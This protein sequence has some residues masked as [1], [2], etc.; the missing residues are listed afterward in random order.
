VAPP[1][2]PHFRLS[3]LG[4][5]C[6]LSAS[7]GACGGDG[8]TGP[9]PGPTPLARDQA[10]LVVDI[11][12]TRV[13]WASDLTR[14]IPVS[15]RFTSRQRELYALAL[16]GQELATRRAHTGID[17]LQAMQDWVTQLYRASPL[18]AAASDGTPQTLDHFNPYRSRPF[19]STARPR[20]VLPGCRR[21]G[22]GRPANQGGDVHGELGETA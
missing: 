22:R 11:G 2:G 21:A 5:A 7:L 14:T 15:G 1:S 9:S 8:G 20:P 16:E 3:R 18:R 4:A 6:V 10:V 12:A 19:V 17:S 13:G